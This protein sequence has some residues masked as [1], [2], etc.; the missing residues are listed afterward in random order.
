MDMLQMFI[1]D[2]GWV[3]F[4]AWSTALV[5]LAA[6]AF[7]KDLLSMTIRVETQKDHL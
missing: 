5:T 3:F 1:F 6:I 7:K 2:L 4:A